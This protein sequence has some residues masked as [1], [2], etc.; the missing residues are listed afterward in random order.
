[1]KEEQLYNEINR[2]KESVKS[3][4]KANDYLKNQPYNLAKYVKV[5]LREIISEI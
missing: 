5:K 3:L 1:M 4:Q 2:L